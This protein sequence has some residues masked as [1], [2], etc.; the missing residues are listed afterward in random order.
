MEAEIIKPRAGEDLDRARLAEYVRDKLPGGELPLFLR[1][2]SGGH[3]NLTYLLTLGERDFVLRRPPMGP[4][5]PLAHDMAR[6]YKVLTALN[7]AYPPAP[8][9]FLFCDDPEIIGADF[10]I[11]ERRLGTVVRK[12]IPEEFGGGRDKKQN[13]ILSETMITA[14]AE[15]HKVDYELIGLGDLG[16]AKGFMK[17]QIRGWAQ[18]YHRA[19]SNEVENAQMVIDWLKAHTPDKFNGAIIHNDWRLDNIMVDSQDPAKLVAVFDWDM[20]TI[21]EPLADLGTLFSTWLE[22]GEGFQRLPEPMPSKVP[23]FMTREEATALY[24]QVSGFDMSDMGYYRVFG[25]F[26]M[27]IVAL[28]IYRRFAE[29]QTQ[30]ERFRHFDRACQMLIDNVAQLIQTGNFS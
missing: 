19:K 2:F 4:V 5:P 25:G 11:M 9:T 1:Q 6:E 26:K 15:L 28:Q 22:P 21:G 30:D 18:A 7:Q 24:G 29:G 17:R 10:F 3:A 13:R 12:V 27:A 8:R 20:C 14:L 16:K 23:G